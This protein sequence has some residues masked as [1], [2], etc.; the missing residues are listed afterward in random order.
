[1]LAPRWRHVGSYEPHFGLTRAETCSAEGPAAPSCRPHPAPT[2]LSLLM[3]VFSI[4][5]SFPSLVLL[6]PTSRSQAWIDNTCGEKMPQS[7]MHC[8]SQP[9]LGLSIARRRAVTSRGGA[10]ARQP[11]RAASSRE[12]W[13][14]IPAPTHC[15]QLP[16]CIVVPCT[17]RDSPRR[18]LSLTTQVVAVW[19]VEQTR[20]SPSSTRGGLCLGLLQALQV[21][22]DSDSYAFPLSMEC[23]GRERCAALGTFLSLKLFTPGRV[24]L[25]L[26][27]W[28]CPES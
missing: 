6:L 3:G 10:S 25:G 1:M 19:P 27:S 18:R 16:S 26:C 4:E 28:K 13:R 2:V 5:N 11:I 22:A 24:A 17:R 21:R 8:V 14:S 7:T 12:G 9:I 23:S 20:G 15:R